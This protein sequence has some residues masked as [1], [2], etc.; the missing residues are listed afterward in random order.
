MDIDISRISFKNEK[1][2]DYLPRTFFQ[3]ETRALGYP[4]PD[5]QQAA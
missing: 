4:A 1:D 3:R 5:R 2:I